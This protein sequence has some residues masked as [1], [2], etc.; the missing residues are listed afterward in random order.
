M[1][2]RLD[3]CARDTK[4]GEEVTLHHYATPGKAAKLV[5]RISGHVIRL[6]RRRLLTDYELFTRLSVDDPLQQEL[7]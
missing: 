4:T 5:E 3:V 6:D 7:V 2:R 1:S